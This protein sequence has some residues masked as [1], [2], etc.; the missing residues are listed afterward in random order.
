MN[1]RA[2][3]SLLGRLMALLALAQ[4]LPIGWCFWFKE[5][6][7]AGAFLASAAIAGVLAGGLRLWG[8]RQQLSGLYR[9]E[10]ILIV[11]VG[12]VLA[13]VLGALPYLL[14]GTLPTL[15]GAIFETA[16]GFTTTGASVLTDI[17][18]Q[19]R[20][21]LFWRSL[22]QWL[23]GLGIIVLFVAL[24]SEL[25]PGARFLYRLEVPGPTSE[26]LQ[27]HVRESAIV[28]WQLYLA[29]TVLQSIL[30][31]VAGLSPY[32]ALT[33]SLSTLSTGGFSPMNAS[34]AAFDSL[35][36]DLII[37]IFMIIAGVNFSLFFLARKQLKLAFRDRELLLYLSIL[38]GVTLYITRDLLVHGQYDSVIDAFRFSGFQVVSMMSST[39]FATADFDLWSDASKALILAAMVIGG[40]AGSTAGGVKVM[41][42]I[43]SIKAALREARRIFKPNTMMAISVGGQNVPGWVSSSVAG[44]II[45]YFVIL[46]GGAL[47]LA[48][49]GN[50]LVTSASAA[51]ACLSNV[52]PGLAAVGPTQNFAHFGAFERLFLVALMILGRL[53]IMA[54]TAALTRAF[55][56]A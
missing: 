39:G 14:S 16:S 48:L 23:G 12:W 42:V 41:R 45:L 1:I 9:R 21:I 30:L 27:P 36:V 11:V 10:G 13:S 25:G 50:D 15:D 49:C 51:L 46:L 35:A 38:A 20:G 28:L 43:V 19:G 4:L 18:G 31:G 40:C 53:E 37:S 55:W 29:L 17:E 6:Q 7:D 8:G 44:F 33:H 26:V 52:G 47:V 2:V 22:T 3:C 32:D 54:I 5:W 34:V 24:L 56:R